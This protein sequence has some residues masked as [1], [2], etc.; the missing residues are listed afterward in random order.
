MNIR[1]VFINKHTMK[2][3]KEIFIKGS[4]YYYDSKDNVLYEDKK[5]ANPITFLFNSKDE[6]KASHNTDNPKDSK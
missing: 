2:K 6:K 1:K 5:K 3:L 4:K